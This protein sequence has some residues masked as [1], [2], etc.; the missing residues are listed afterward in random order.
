MMVQAL[1]HRLLSGPA[2]AAAWHTL[3]A[4]DDRG[5]IVGTLYVSQCAVD[6]A[7]DR[8]HQGKTAT[9][10]LLLRCFEDRPVTICA[11][12]WRVHGEARMPPGLK[13][14]KRIAPA[15]VMNQGDVLTLR[16]EWR[17]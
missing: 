5:R 12:D 6:A 3:N 11:M 2:S 16:W 4:M 15:I 10:D 13:R 17:P 7:V 8:L 14:H 9:F 1:L